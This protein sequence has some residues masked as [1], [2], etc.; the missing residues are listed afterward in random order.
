[1][2]VELKV[3]ELPPNMC[4]SAVQCLLDPCIRKACAGFPESA[5]VIVK[6]NGMSDEEFNKLQR[7][8]KRNPLFKLSV[9]RELRKME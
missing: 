3:R 9:M 6:R 4:D 1:V 8:M 5:Q 2:K 7:R